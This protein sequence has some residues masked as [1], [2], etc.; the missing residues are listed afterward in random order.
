MHREA[1]RPRV[2]VLGLGSIGGFIAGSL[3]EAPGKTPPQVTLLFHRRSLLNDFIDNG[4]KLRLGT[5][6]GEVRSSGNFDVEVLEDGLEH[7]WVTTE[8][9]DSNIILNPRREADDIIDYLII[10]VKAVQTVSAL[11]PLK[12]RIDFSTTILFLQNGCGTIDEVNKQLFPHPSTRPTQL[13][14]VISHGV[15]LNSPF[16]VS[17][18]GAAA[19]SV[20]IVPRAGVLGDRPRSEMLDE[21]EEKASYLLDLLPQIPRL[22]A[23]AYSFLG[24]FQMQLEKLAVNSFCNPLC[25]LADSINKYLFSIPEIRRDLLSEISRVILALP[26]LKGVEGVEDRFSTDKLEATVMAILTK[27]ADGLCSLVVDLRQGRQTEVEFING[28]WVRR[29]K[30][31]GVPTPLNEDL[32]RQV[33]ARAKRGGSKTQ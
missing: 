24:V 2:H 22:N 1:I 12:H 16:D 9:A 32:V 21:M 4:C 26:E 31:V 23:T 14:G 18:T 6:D 11:R 3:A 30:E 27:T 7:R 13:I 15:T 10:T 17:H 29:G 5:L 8:E 19:T 20:G 28:Y 25:A 33:T